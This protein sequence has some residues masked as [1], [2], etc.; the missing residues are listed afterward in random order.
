MH[1]TSVSPFLQTQG[2]CFR[3]QSL[4]LRVQ[5]ARCRPSCVREDCVELVPSLCALIRSSVRGSHRGSWRMQAKE[6][7]VRLT[8]PAPSGL[9]GRARLN[10]ALEHSGSCD[11]RVSN[12]LHSF[13]SEEKS[14]LN[15]YNNCRSSFASLAGDCIRSCRKSTK[16]GANQG[17]T[18]VGQ[19]IK[20]RQIGGLKDHKF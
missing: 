7:S 17:K 6:S 15:R 10:S 3:F 13:V 8:S 19:P 9:R 5:C 16:S 14:L 18:T 20:M 11:L 4:V 2:S 12:K 1:P